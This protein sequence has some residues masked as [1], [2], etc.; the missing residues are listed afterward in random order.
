MRRIAL[1]MMVAFVAINFTACS[2]QDSK[3]KIVVIHTGYG[4]MKLKLFNET[5]LHRDNF[6]KLVKEG[7]YEDSPFHRVIKGFMIQGG[8]NADGRQ[9]PGYTVEAEFVPTYFHKKGALAAARMPDNVNPEK[10]SS[11]SQFYIVHGRTFTDE[12]IDFMEKKYNK[13]FTEAQKEAYK[14]EGGAPHLDGD[15]TVFGQ[16]IEGYDV[17]DKIA[18]VQTDKR[19]N[20]PLQDVTMTIEVIE[21]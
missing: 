1:I 11:G 3:E 8:G 17:V 18:A 2:Q 12:E 16:L 7:W 10:R 15:Y 13:T 5:P 9:D 6:I 20:K 4:D 19:A 21:E 14:T